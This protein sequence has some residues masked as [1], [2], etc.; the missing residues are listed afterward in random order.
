V[1]GI[2]ECDDAG[3]LGSFTVFDGD[4]LTSAMHDLDQRYLADIDVPEA[5]RLGVELIRTWNSRD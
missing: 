1:L 4:D 2:Y 5:E 3:R